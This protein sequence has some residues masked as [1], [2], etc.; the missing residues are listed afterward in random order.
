M[1]PVDEY[2]AVDMASEPIIVFACC[3]GIRSQRRRGADAIR[4]MA[5]FVNHRRWL[6]ILRGHCSQHLALQAEALVSIGD[7]AVWIDQVSLY[8]LNL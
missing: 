4:V 6:I 8:F 5:G 1:C 7:A 2:P 3:F